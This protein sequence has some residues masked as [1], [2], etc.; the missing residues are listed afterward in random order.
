MAPVATWGSTHDA[1]SHYM[2]N[3]S[4]SSSSNSNSN[5]NVV[6]VVVVVVVVAA[7]A[8]AAAAVVVVTLLA[9]A[10]STEEAS[11][12][13]DSAKPLLSDCELPC[14]RS[15]PTHHNGTNCTLLP[16]D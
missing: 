11:V 7:A 9:V 15:T 1:D 6:V 13:S 5:S 3:Y 2:L 4:G 14:L 12:S 10:G 16:Q 8:A